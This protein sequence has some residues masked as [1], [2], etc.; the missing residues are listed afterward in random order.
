MAEV[1]RD[2]LGR[3]RYEHKYQHGLPNEETKV[4]D[5][6]QAIEH[7]SF[8]DK[9]HKSYLVLLYWLGCRRGE[10]LRYIVN[11]KV[12]YEGV[13][14]ED[15]KLKGNSLFMKIPAFKGG[16]RGGSIELP[17]SFYGIE[18]IRERW[19]KTKP[20][21]LL[22]NFTPFTGWRIIKR[23]WPEKSPHWLRHNRI[24]KIR[25]KIDGETLSLDDAKSFTGIKSD[26]TMQNYGMRTQ[27]GIHRV[28]Q[29]L[30]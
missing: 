30:D 4:D 18:L 13:K 10:P 19:E 25:K 16:I 7:G 17:L 26:R 14:K 22:W 11:G 5:L 1:L 24:T 2:K 20:G 27:D 6:K 9:K 12:K 3:V 21:R 23:V 29:T 28:S 15:V 8:K